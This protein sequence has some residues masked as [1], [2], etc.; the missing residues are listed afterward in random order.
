MRAMK[1]EKLNERAHGPLITR[2]YPIA[3]LIRLDDT[4]I[5]Q[6]ADFKECLG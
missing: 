6:L 3:R 5:N 1:P 2:L 4:C